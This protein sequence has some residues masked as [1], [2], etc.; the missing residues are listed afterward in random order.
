MGLS[1]SIDLAE[2]LFTLF[3]VF[4]VGLVI[5][6]Q[7]EAKREGYPL[8]SDNE[9]VVVQG[10]PAVPEPKKYKMPHG[11]PPVK[12]PREET[13]R[14]LKL[15]PTAGF[16]GAPFEPTGENPMLDGVGPGSY[17]NRHDAPELTLPGEPRFV[18]MRTLPDFHVDENDPNPVGMEVVGADNEVAG[19]VTDLWVDRVEPMIVFFEV[20]LGGEFG[21]KVL[22]PNNFSRVYRG[23]GRIKVHSIYA[24]QFKD[25]PG[26]AAE[27][28]I[29][30]LEEEKIVAY[31]G[32][33][34]LYAD[35]K[36]AEPII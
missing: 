26:I 9:G 28:T 4:F 23:K 30:A 17:A 27:E 22:V 11:M 33:G 14:E 35:E 31:F 18:P 25:I 32:A 5:Y 34:T 8:E 15:R 6:L 7:R 13:E 1:S 12:A 24:H 21:K 20:Q 29:T 16:P 2:I 3:W 19:V 10:F 36:R